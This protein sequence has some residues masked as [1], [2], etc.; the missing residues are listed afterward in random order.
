MEC[1][2]YEY[3]VKDTGEVILLTHR[4]VYVPETKQ[5]APVKQS[6]RQ[7]FEPDVNTFSKNGKYEFEEEF[8]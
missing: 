3:T 4:Y 2:P 1:P 6:A 8:A 5:S 7:E